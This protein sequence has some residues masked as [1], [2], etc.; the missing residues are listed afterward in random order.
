MAP[1][2]NIDLVEASQQFDLTTWPMP[3]NTAATML[4]CAR[5]C[6]RAGGL[7]ETELGS[8]YVQLSREHLLRPGPRQPIPTSRSWRPRATA[9]RING[10]IY[11]S[12]LTPERGRGWNVALIITGD[13]WDE[14]I[15]LERRRR[16]SEHV[17]PLP[18][19][20]QG[21]VGPSGVTVR[22]PS[23]TAPDI[24]ADANPET[25]VSVYEPELIRRLGPG[26]WHQR[27]D[28]HHG[29]HDR[30]RRPGPRVPGRP[31]VE[32]PHPDPPGSLRGI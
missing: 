31:T 9:A 21:V 11:P 14:R 3:S 18:S 8:S 30:D 15:G 17:F 12:S 20:Q 23:R 25:G 6:R 5:W 24:S 29:R 13:T 4:G 32:R 22:S 2:A 1:D 26:G 10:P 28:A 7:L 27:G 19:Y 16:R